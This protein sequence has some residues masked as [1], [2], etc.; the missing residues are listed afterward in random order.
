MGNLLPD[1]AL[2][3]RNRLR[4]DSVKIAAVLDQ[5]RELIETP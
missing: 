1:W 4:H 3:G 5:E 2:A